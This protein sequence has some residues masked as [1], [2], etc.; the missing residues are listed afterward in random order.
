MVNPGHN[1]K[2]W[3]SGKVL[4]VSDTLVQFPEI[5]NTE[6]L[7]ICQRQPCLPIAKPSRNMIP[8]TLAVLKPYKTSKIGPQPTIDENSD[9]CNAVTGFA[10]DSQKKR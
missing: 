6:V 10:I 4:I 7:K 3:R 9:L 1:R 5:T 8:R 2:M